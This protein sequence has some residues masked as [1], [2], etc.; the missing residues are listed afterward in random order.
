MIRN[1]L[2]L[3]V[4]ILLA[5]TAPSQEPAAAPA[6][7]PKSVPAIIKTDGYPLDTCIVSGKALGEGAKTVEVAGRTYKTC[8]GKCPAKIEAEPAQYAEKLDAAIVAQQQANYPLTKC[9]VSGKALDSMGGP[10]SIVLDGK[11][12]QLCCGNCTKR[13]TAR[14]AEILADLEEAALQAQRKGYL[15][16]TC[17]V[18]GHDLDEQAVEVVHGNTLIKLCCE[19]CI[20]KVQA[21]PNEIAAKVTAENRK[22][23]QAKAEKAEKEQPKDKAPATPGKDR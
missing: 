13:A 18:S 22:L 9:V 20:E 23:Q 15:S 2:L 19:D 10:K 6:A 16:T 3:F 4:P 7:A 5:L 14:K 1:S 17:P 21:K 11:L 12:V 8:C